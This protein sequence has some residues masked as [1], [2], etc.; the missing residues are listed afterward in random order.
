MPDIALRGSSLRALARYTLSVF[1]S[2]RSILSLIFFAAALVQ[3]F[4]RVSLLLPTWVWI[5][6]VVIGIYLS[7]FQVYSQLEASY[8]KGAALKLEC[9]RV[10]FG[11]G[12]W[13]NRMPLLPLNFNLILTLRNTGE[14]QAQLKD[15][16]VSAFRSGTTLIS[17][18]PRPPLLKDAP[19]LSSYIPIT[20]PFVVEADYLNPHLRCEIRVDLAE[21]DPPAFAKRLNELDQFHLQ[22]TYTYEGLRGP[23]RTGTCDIDGSFA[24][25]KAEVIQRWKETKDHDLVYAATGL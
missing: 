23:V 4:T 17:A 8:P 15:I 2:W 24:D 21:E 16:A 19:P 5:M 20:L 11:G 25:F 1:K 22:V 3:T 6:L 14:E 18:S 13:A 12:G 10:S 7:A 9:S